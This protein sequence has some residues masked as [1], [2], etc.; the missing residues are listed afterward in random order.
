MDT[1]YFIYFLQNNVHG[2]YHTYVPT[3]IE[4]MLMMMVH[5]S[6]LKLTFIQNT[7]K[8]YTCGHEDMGYQLATYSLYLCLTQVV[9]LMINMFLF[10]ENHFFL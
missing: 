7:L 10:F 5:L 3:Y 6:W 8:L 4:W 1:F 2:Q 9:A